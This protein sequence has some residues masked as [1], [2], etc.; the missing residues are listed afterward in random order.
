MIRP[1]LQWI[2]NR[3]PITPASVIALWPTMTRS[4]TILVGRYGASCCARWS[5]S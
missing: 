4:L 2:A 5:T 1:T 3:I